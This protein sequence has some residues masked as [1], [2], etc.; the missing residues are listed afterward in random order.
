MSDLIV[1]RCP[2]IVTSKKTGKSYVCNQICGAYKPGSA[3]EAWCRFCKTEV[4]FE[5]KDSQ[6][7]LPAA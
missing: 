7:V 1:V 5:I 3:G 4:V 6:V 2:R